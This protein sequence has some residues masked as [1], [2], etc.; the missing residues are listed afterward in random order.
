MDVVIER[1]SLSDS[2]IVVSDSKKIYSTQD[3]LTPLMTASFQGHSRVVRILIEAKAQVNTQE[4]V[5]CSYH[6][7][8]TAQRISIITSVIAVLGEL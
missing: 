4:E 5:S 6:Q 8:C 2:Y 3:G 7:K 1:I